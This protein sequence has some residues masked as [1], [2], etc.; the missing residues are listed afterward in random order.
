MVC[1]KFRLP[2]LHLYQSI[3]YNQSFARHLWS[4]NPQSII[5]DGNPV[6]IQSPSRQ[7]AIKGQGFYRFNE[8]KFS[9]KDA[10]ESTTTFENF[11]I[12]VPKLECSFADDFSRLVLTK[13]K[14]R[15]NYVLL[16]ALMNQLSQSSLFS[17]KQT[18]L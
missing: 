6:L 17:G 14:G 2:L 9:I 13:Q 7:L 18:V 16:Q 10:V 8:L 1:D 5:A 4:F 12:K 11:S 15:A 3:R